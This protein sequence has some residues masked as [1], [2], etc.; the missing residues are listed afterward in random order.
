MKIIAY[1]NWKIARIVL[2]RKFIIL[3]SY[4]WI[5]EKSQMKK[6]RKTGQDGRVERP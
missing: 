3:N 2:R 6:P 5:E 4:I 1:Q